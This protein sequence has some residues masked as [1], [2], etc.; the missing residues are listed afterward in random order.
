MNVVVDDGPTVVDCVLGVRVTLQVFHANAGTADAPKA[1]SVAS[2]PRISADFLFTRL[3]YDSD[4]IFC[5][6]SLRSTVSRA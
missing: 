5:I 1:T 6:Y 4:R 2:N 3:M